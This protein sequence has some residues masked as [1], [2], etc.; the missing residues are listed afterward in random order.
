MNFNKNKICF[1]YRRWL[2]LTGVFII[3]MGNAIGQCPDFVAWQASSKQLIVKYN[4]SDEAPL[5]NK[6]S[7]SI[8][9]NIDVPKSLPVAI[10]GSGSELRY[11]VLDDNII[12]ALNNLETEVYLYDDEVRIDF[13]ITTHFPNSNNIVCEF[14]EIPITCPDKITAFN[15]PGPNDGIAFH[16]DDFMNVNSVNYQN[17]VLSFHNI[18]EQ[19]GI[20]NGEGL[21][22]GRIKY[23]DVPI[24]S[25]DVTAYFGQGTSD[26]KVCVYNQGL[27]C[28]TCPPEGNNEDCLTDFLE[29]R[30][31]AMAIIKEE[32][33]CKQWDG[34][35]NFQDR[36]FR[37]G[38]V[39]IG[40]SNFST[41][42]H[43]GVRKGIMTEQFKVQTY[44]EW[45]DYVFDEEYDLLSLNEVEQH[46]NKRGH[47]PNTPSALEI[48]SQGYFDIGEVQVN[49]QEKI[50]EIFL[51]LI[52]LKKEATNLKERL[53]VLKEENQALVK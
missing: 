4:S 23:C 16:Y 32:N 47:L 42:F 11:S 10:F 26:E 13:T 45:A 50:E 36:T 48:E 8:N 22:G 2:V 24:R 46:I 34:D 19:N 7:F 51:H 20:Y 52:S 25:Y 17:T 37:D 35:C 53:K 31:E 27:L 14:V 40:S 9:N 21:L 41:D 43:L 18:P 3:G 28:E 6:V 15:C 30:D 44:G 38:K 49:H 12:D 33:N 5:D 1:F 29:C 39:L